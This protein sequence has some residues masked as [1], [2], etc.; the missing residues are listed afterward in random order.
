MEG[1]GQVRVRPPGGQDVRFLG[2]EEVGE[3]R[4]QFR[5]MRRDEEV[6]NLVIV[7]WTLRRSALWAYFVDSP[8]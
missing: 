2:Q 1:T 8:S 5:C 7:C 6:L 3:L 4:L